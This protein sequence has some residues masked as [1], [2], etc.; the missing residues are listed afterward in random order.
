MSAIAATL[1]GSKGTLWNY[2]PSKE[3]LFNAVMDRVTK[4]FRARLTL[5]LNTQG[6]VETTLRRFC[7]EFLGKVTAPESIALYRLVIS[8]ASRFPEVGR[9]FHER[10]PK[11]TQEQLAQYLTGVMGQGLLRQADPLF[12]ARQMI[13][14]CL[15]GSHQRLLTGVIE[16]ATPDLIGEDIDRAMEIFM[17][18][19]APE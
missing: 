11:L 13:G 3:V 7:E 5:I 2:F 1:G 15:S 9:I 17:R 16:K 10:G 4:D 8:E 12:A 18:G 14:L 19:Y 6:E